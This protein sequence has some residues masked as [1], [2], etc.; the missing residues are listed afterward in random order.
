[1][2]NKLKGIRAA[3]AYDVKSAEL[4][5]AHNNANILTLGERLLDAEKAK[6]IVKTFLEVPFE[7]GRHEARVEKIAGLETDSD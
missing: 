2:A 4:A 7:G 6:E 3:N 5:R 1:A